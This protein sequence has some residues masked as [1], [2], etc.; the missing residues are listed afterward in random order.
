[1]KSGLDDAGNPVAA[2]QFKKEAVPVWTEATATNLNKSIAIILDNKVIYDPVVREI[3]PNG[4]C[5]ISGRFTA[6]ELK[7]ISILGNN[8]ELPAEFTIVK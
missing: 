6:R 2:I 1:M 8:G 7:Y 3:I 5:V 4:S